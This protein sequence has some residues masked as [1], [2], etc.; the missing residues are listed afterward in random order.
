[1][2]RA[3]VS[4]EQPKGIGPALLLQSQSLAFAFWPPW[5]LWSSR[6]VCVERRLYVIYHKYMLFSI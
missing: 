4:G 1:L 6:K 5:G 2:E 3:E